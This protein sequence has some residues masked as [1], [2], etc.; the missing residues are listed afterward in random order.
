[1]NIK[2]FVFNPVEENTYVLYDETKS[3]IVIDAGC[4]FPQEQKE[5]VHF[6]DSNALSLKRIINTHSHFDHVFGNA[7]LNRTYHI[8]PE[9]H[10]DDEPYLTNIVAYAGSFGFH[11]GVEY[12]PIANYLNDGDLIEFGNTCL[13]AIHVPGHSPGSLCFYNEKEKVLFSGDVLFEGSVGRTDLLGG[14][15]ETLIHGITRKILTLPDETVVYPGHGN[16]TTIGREKQ[17][18]PYL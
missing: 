8:L 18:N 16:S 5:L 11:S 2:C 3:C 12:Q 4:Y 1:M 9:A 15:Y 13:K 10:K 17:Y 7:F 6:I 14:N